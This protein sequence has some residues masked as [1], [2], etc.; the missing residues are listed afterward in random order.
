[1]T[2]WKEINNIFDSVISN[3]NPFLNSQTNFV[4]ILNCYYF[5]F[6]FSVQWVQT[7]L[8]PSRIMRHDVFH[9]II[10]YIQQTLEVSTPST[11]ELEDKHETHKLATI[12]TTRNTQHWHSPRRGAVLQCHMSPS[13]CRGSDRICL[14][15][16]F[17]FLRLLCICKMQIA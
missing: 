15:F 16:A 2:F 9:F 1:M 7:R 4:I 6:L 17:A 3:H 10:W 13:H 14:A 5:F 11:S 8:H 12:K